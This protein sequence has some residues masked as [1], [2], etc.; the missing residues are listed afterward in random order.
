MQRACLQRPAP[1]LIRLSDVPISAAVLVPC[2][3]GPSDPPGD[4]QQ[5]DSNS[6]MSVC[7]C[8]CIIVHTAETKLEH[9]LFNL[10]NDLTLVEK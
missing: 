4:G 5:D 1:A 2:K 7:V 6:L 8:V 10:S 3:G 9:P